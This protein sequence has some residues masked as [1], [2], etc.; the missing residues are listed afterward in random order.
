MQRRLN[1]LVFAYVF[2]PDAGS[3][4]YRTL[5]F[6]NHW[7]RQ[8]D[9]VTII[10]VNEQCFLSTALIDRGL[11]KEVHPSIR[12]VRASATRPLQKLLEIRSAFHR[13]TSTIPDADR[14]KRLES[15]ARAHGILR[16]VKDTISDFLSCPDEHIGWVPDAVRRGY[17]ITK[18]TR[19]DCIY[20]TGGPWSCLL[21]AALVHKLSDIPLVLDFRDPWISNPNLIAKS[22]FSRR[23][24]TKMESMCVNSSKTVI[25]NTE[26]LRQDFLSRY[27][28]LN[29][30]RF[31]TITNGFEDMPRETKCS[32]EH[33]TLLHAGAIYQPRNP[34]N[35]LK[36][37]SELVK[38]GVIPAKTFRVQL[39]GGASIDDSAVEL[40][41]RSGVLRNVV[42]IT[43]R[44]SH[45]DAL[46][47]QRRASALLLIQTGFPLQVPRKLYEY[48]SLARPILAIAEHDSATARMVNDL[49]LGY[50]VDDNIASIKKAIMALYES[51]RSGGTLSIDEEKLHTYHN[52]YLSGRLRDIMRP[53]LQGQ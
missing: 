40:E 3:G 22:A 12:V 49:R 10:T 33:F 51:W 28:N 5:Y 25:A 30:G 29:P 39:V 34:L 41:L 18:S 43:P 48:L 32:T 4:T 13:K 8:G 27:A 50:V 38:D 45:D 15:S 37:V 24:Q 16:Q 35:L 53:F 52:R 2:P 17:R 46:A 23:L 26:E 1:I 6:A 21:A 7:A 47:L 31:V 11:C 36:A 19:V 9:G 44:V 14:G 42:E 20:A